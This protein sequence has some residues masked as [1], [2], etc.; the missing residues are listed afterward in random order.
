MYGNRPGGMVLA[1]EEE[2]YL[3][4]RLHAKGQDI[5]DA[6]AR[7]SRLKASLSRRRF[8]TLSLAV[9]KAVIADLGRVAGA[10]QDACL[11]ARAHHRRHSR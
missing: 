9:P 6:M 5:P 3:V 7:L 2:L 10:W 4:L 8:E 1:E 11:R